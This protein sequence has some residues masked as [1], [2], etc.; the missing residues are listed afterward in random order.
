M[1]VECTNLFVLDSPFMEEGYRT[2]RYEL[3]QMKPHGT[4][5]L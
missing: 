1:F 5:R 3:T 2:S 4:G